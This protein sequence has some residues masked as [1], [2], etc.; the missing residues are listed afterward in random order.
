VIQE[1]GIETFCP[2]NQKEWRL[3]LKK[4]HKS[5]QSV[6]LIL[7]KKESN[8]PIISWSDAVDQALC[9]GWVDSKRKPIDREKFMQFFSKRKS[10]GT[11]SKINK[12]KVRQLIDQGLMTPAGLECIETAK[13]NGSW[14]ILDDV[15]AFKIPKDLAKEFKIKPGS[16]DFFLSLS[17]SVRKR[18]LLW[19]VFAKRPETRQKRIDEIVG[20]ASLA[21][22]PKQFR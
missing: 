17:K 4:N 12:E 15:E 7:Y 10:T 9:F 3:W 8:K 13:Q 20:N 2:T 6:W 14:I 16:K 1:K 19:L 11:W 18:I 21:L 5:K 22:R